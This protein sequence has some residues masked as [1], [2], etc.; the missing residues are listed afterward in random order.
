MTHDHASPR[1]RAGVLA[2]ALALATMI[3]GPAVASP[4]YK[5][6][7]NRVEKSGSTKFTVRRSGTDLTIEK[8]GSTQ[9]KAVQRGSKMAVEVSGSA[10]ATT[11]NGKIYKSGSTWGTVA[12]AQKQ[13]DCDGTVAATLWVLFQLG[14]LP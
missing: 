8:S 5:C 6:K 2:V 11:E 12:D 3:A 7:D 1:R 10:T 4:E 14:I 13:F 9:G